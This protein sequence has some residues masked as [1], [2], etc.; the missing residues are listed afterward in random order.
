MGVAHGVGQ[1]EFL[2]FLVGRHGTLRLPWR[3]FVQSG[4][5]GFGHRLPDGAIACALQV[6]KTVVDGLV[7]QSTHGFPIGGVQGFLARR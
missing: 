2:E 6:G 7:G 5:H 4:Q 3:R 1:H